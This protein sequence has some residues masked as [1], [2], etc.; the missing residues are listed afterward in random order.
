MRY[1]RRFLEFV[2]SRVM[3]VTVITALLIMSFYMAMNIAN[4]YV[5]VDDGLD[6]RAEVPR[7]GGK[8]WEQQFQG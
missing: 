8:L 6:A 5:M 3:I 2:A 7:T 1:V 4:I